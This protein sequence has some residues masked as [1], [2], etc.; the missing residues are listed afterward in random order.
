[1]KRGTITIICILFGIAS[2]FTK[3][4]LAQIERATVLGKRQVSSSDSMQLKRLWSNANKC[5][6]Y[7]EQR[8]KTLD[9]ALAIMPWNAYY[10]QQKAMPL[11]KRKKYELGAPYLDSAVKYDAKAY[12][13]YR[14]V[15]K[16]LFQKNYREAIADFHA[17]RALLGNGSVMDH[18]YDFYLGLCH[19][20]LNAFDSAEYFL[21]RTTEQQKAKLGEDWVHPTDL[22]YLGI[23]YYEKGAYATAIETF[24]RSINRYKNFSD[25]KFYKAVCLERLNKKAEAETLFKEAKNDFIDGATINEDN[26]IYESYPYQVDRLV[27]YR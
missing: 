9:S 16:C 23:V 24:D 7:S 21:R 6:L 5:P 25:A 15:M 2:F 17:S 1:M 27:H 13:D 8:Q 11:Y 14:G 12:I 26:Y 20:Q 19:L 22:F 10:W 4:S 3:A 18:T